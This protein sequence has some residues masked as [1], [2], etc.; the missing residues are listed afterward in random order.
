MLN[1]GKLVEGNCF[2]SIPYVMPS[3]Y[4]NLEYQMLVAEIRVTAAYAEPGTFIS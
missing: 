1:D 3:I 2:N 4:I